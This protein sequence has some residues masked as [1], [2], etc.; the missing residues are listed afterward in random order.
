MIFKF[1]PNNKITRERLKS[2]IEWDVF[3][4]IAT[5]IYNLKFKAHKCKDEHTIIVDGTSKIGRGN[6]GE[7]SWKNKLYIG[8]AYKTQIRLFEII[9]HEWCH[10]NQY[11]IQQNTQNDILYGS[12]VYAHKTKKHKYNYAEVEADQWGL[13]GMQALTVYKSIIKISKQM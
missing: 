1:K 12:G 5:N 8:G 7:Y 4:N 10:W 9:Y 11:M 2:K 3:S 13:T 6:W